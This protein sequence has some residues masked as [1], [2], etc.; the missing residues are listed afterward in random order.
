MGE[1]DAAAPELRLVFRALR[2]WVHGH[3]INYIVQLVFWFPPL[4]CATDHDFHHATQL[5]KGPQGL[6]L[7]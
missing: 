4:G 5:W 2:L 7:I 1:G 6:P 3:S